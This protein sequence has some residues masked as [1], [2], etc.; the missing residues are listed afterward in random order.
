LKYL[1]DT[2]IISEIVS[3]QPNK[4]VLNFLEENKDNLYLSVI[5]IG[6]INAGIEKLEQSK[7]KDKLKL[8]LQSL[9]QKFEDKILNIDIYIM[10]LWGEISMKLQKNGISISIMDCLIASCAIKENMILV[11]RNEKD[12]KDIENL[13]IINPFKG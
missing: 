6:E 8:W 5:T 7:R 10:L 1:L 13:I 2:N 9:L 12:F 11:T 4:K 3:K